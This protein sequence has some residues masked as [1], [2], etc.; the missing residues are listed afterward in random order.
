VAI[1]ATIPKDEKLDELSPDQAFELLAIRREKL[2]LEP[3]QA[4]IESQS[5][6]DFHLF[7]HHSPLGHFDLVERS[8][9]GRQQQL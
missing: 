2:G 6:F 1:N 4:D 8:Y 3:G 9:S 5:C 7:L